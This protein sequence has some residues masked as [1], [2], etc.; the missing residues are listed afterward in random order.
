M[1]T[2]KIGTKV[3]INEKELLKDDGTLVGF[4]EAVGEI[5]VISGE[6]EGDDCYPIDIIGVNGLTLYFTEDH[7]DLIEK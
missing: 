5:G 7:F 3:L 2:F 4:K 6:I 1:K